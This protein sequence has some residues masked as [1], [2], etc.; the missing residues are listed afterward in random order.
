MIHYDIETHTKMVGGHEVHVPYILGF[1][2]R[3]GVFGYFAGDDCVNN[4]VRY[5]VSEISRREENGVLV[6]SE[7]N[8]L[9]L[10]AYDGRNFDH[11]FLSRV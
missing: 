1:V 10:N 3:E 6:T 5:I 2:G 8:E 7:I 11:Y 9:V 4:F